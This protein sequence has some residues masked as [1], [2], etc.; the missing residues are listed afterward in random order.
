MV[1]VRGRAPL[2]VYSGRVKV[3]GST[4]V[5]GVFD[6]LGIPADFRHAI[7]AIKNGRV[8]QHSEIVGDGAALDLIIMPEGG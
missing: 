2:D 1:E 8:V 5:N 6:A 7:I 3:T 4:D